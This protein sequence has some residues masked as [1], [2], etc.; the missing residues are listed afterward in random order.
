MATLEEVL[1]PLYLLHR[2]QVEAS[3]KVLGG[4]SYTYA[5]RGDGQIV[6]DPV[7]AQEQRRA[8]KAL[9]K[10]LTPDAL[11]V[12]E[13][14]LPL[15]PPRPMGYPQHRELFPS[16]TGLTFDALSPAEVASN[17][18]LSLLL[19]PERA[20]RLIE[21]HA[22]DNSKPG[23]GE[24]LDAIMSQTWKSRHGAGY[25]G[26]IQRVVD[27]VAL[28]HLFS[29]ATGENTLGQVKG[30]ATLKLSELKDWVT[31]Q[32]KRTKDEQQRAHLLFAASQIGWFEEDPKEFSFPRPAEPPPG[33][34]PADCGWG[35][36]RSDSG[37]T[38]PSTAWEG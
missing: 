3:A 6:T 2:Y 11:K 33:H 31:A 18:V 7:A 8:L 14:L 35:P 36:E 9:L 12:P 38:D 32:T 17:H 10:T 22:M 19:N 29:L 16:R 1:V 34:L 26:E 24:V 25:D 37:H 20:A 4:L 15:L 21:H 23:L 5:M 27:N 28:Y 13:K 30:I